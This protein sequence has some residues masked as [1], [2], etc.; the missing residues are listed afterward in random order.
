MRGQ[1]KIW[2]EQ[3]DGKVIVLHPLTGNL[4]FFHRLV[5]EQKVLGRL[6]TPREFVVFRNNNTKD[7]EPANLAVVDRKPWMQF[8]KSKMYPYPSRL[9]LLFL[10][11]VLHLSA[12][13]I[14]M[15]YN[16]PMTTIDTMFNERKIQTRDVR[17]RNSF[18]LKWNKF[19]RWAILYFRN[20]RGRGWATA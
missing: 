10:Y 5:A 8:K 18:A 1:K 2:Y 20:S 19:M 17:K 4:V 7:I 3:P 11:W 15:L 12:G 16:V 14:S 13:T 9:T 6:L